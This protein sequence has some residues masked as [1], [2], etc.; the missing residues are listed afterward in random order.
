M[1]FEINVTEKVVRTNT[2]VVEVEDEDEGESLLCNIDGDISDA[3]H[4]DDITSI[5]T[6]A[7]YEVQEMVYGA[8][9]AEYELE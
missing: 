5:I 7:G 8:E 3:D 1:R 6:E 4:P 9:G 2:Y